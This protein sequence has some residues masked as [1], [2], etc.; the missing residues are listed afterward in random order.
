MTNLPSENSSII[1][2]IKPRIDWLDYAKG[3][4]IFLV[5]LGHV[6]RGL[7][8]SANLATPGQFA[9]IDSW[10]YSFHMPLFFFLSGLFSYSANRKS[11]KDFFADKFRNIIYPYLIWSVITARAYF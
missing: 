7:Y 6:I 4:G 2:A 8:D 5:V 3:I 10:I 11:I 1:T 9:A